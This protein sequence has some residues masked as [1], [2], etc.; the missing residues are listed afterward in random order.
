M[1]NFKSLFKKTDEIIYKRKKLN[2]YEQ[3]K[4]PEDNESNNNDYFCCPK[5]KERILISL[6]PSN[7]TVSYNCENNHEETHLDY[8]FFY[9]NRYINK[10]SLI[11]QQCKKEKINN[12]KIIICSVCNMKLCGICILKHKNTYKHN[13]FGLIYNSVK[14]CSKH[15]LDISQFCKTCQKN[16]CTFCV[17][18]NDENNEHYNHDIINF[19]DLI[20]DDKEIKDNRNKLNQKIMKNNDIINKLKKWKNEMCSLID[21]TIDKLINEKLINQMIIQKF[22]WKYLDYI[23]YQNYNTALEKLDIMNEDLEKF[24][25]SKMFIEQTNAINDYLFGK[26]YR[27]NN[28]NDIND[29]NIINEKKENKKEEKLTNNEIQQEIQFNIINRENLE[30]INNNKKYEDMETNI[31]ET[32]KKEDAL[33]FSKNNSIYSYSLENNKFV[34]LFENVDEEKNENNKTN[35]DNIYKNIIDL[36]ANL[37]N[38]IGNYN[39][40]IWKMEQDMAKDKI[41]DLIENNKKEQT[42]KF[43]IIQISENNNFNIPKQIINKSI[44]QQNAIN[45]GSNG[46]LLFSEDNSLFT[47]NL[48]SNVN[49]NN[50]NNNSLFN[51]LNINNE[52]TRIFTNFN[53]SNNNI[54]N[55]YL[56]NNNI[57]EEP[58][59][60][61]YVYVSRT[62][63][64]YHGRPQCG[65]M[66]SST[67]MTLSKAESLGLGPCMK[68][69]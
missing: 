69:Y 46:N 54:N 8:N 29:N 41:I 16:L 55:N 43:K 45:G 25:K 35:N 60:E 7:F 22:N 49:N 30:E 61:E 66:K 21:E 68:C 52:N 13:N 6:N 14:K 33:L 53:S 10:N 38:K 42:N 27:Q 48:N 67:R 50:S 34:K 1:S 36:K 26:N 56:F 20:P 39:I 47:S 51:N 37:S 19:S 64:K 58:A 12:N 15:D 65:R 4:N 59:Q 9:N 18:K 31:I 3:I 32:L 63:S 17:K 62:G 23:N 44:N 57:I 28:D 24:Y 40:F 2:Q 11:C 5:C